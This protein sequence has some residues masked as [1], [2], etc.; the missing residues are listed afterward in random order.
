MK[1]NDATERKLLAELLRLFTDP[2]A[3]ARRQARRAKW[4]M[5]GVLT[6]ILAAAVAGGLGAR[7]E[8][9][10]VLMLIAGV[11]IGYYVWLSTAAQQLPVR[12][13]TLDVEAIRRRLA[14]GGGPAA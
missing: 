7:P 5:A 12:Y 3:A 6:F 13:A 1:T 11:L 9:E 8:V 10:A 4:C 2:A 14:E